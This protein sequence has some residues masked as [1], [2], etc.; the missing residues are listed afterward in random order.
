MNHI[1]FCKIHTCTSL[2]ILTYAMLSNALH[3]LLLYILRF[4]YFILIFYMI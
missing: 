1:S 2:L 4:P 3:Y